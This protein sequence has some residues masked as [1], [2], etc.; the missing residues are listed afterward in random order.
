MVGFIIYMHPSFTPKLEY[1][2][3][4]MSGHAILPPQQENWLLK[5]VTFVSDDKELVGTQNVNAYGHCLI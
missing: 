3:L 4:K 5:A 2:I 1:A